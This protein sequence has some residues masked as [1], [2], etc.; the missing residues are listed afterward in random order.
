M[1]AI[2]QPNSKEPLPPRESGNF[3]VVPL[4]W[5]KAQIISAQVKPLKS[6]NGSGLNLELG[7]L[8]TGYVNRKVWSTL[9][10]NHSSPQVERIG[11]QQLQEL[12]EATGFTRAT[13]HDD[14]QL[15]GKIVLVKLKIDE[16]KGDYPAR[17]QASGFA[18]LSANKTLVPPPSGMTTGGGR[19]AASSSTPWA[20]GQQQPAA[21]QPAAQQP[22]AQQ[23]IPQADQ[24]GAPAQT[25]VSTA[26]PR[27]GNTPPWQR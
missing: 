26:A 19:P 10:V 20:N 1:A 4:G 2:P 18:P 7:L 3:P 24:Q 25:Q 16:A 11:Q 6:N 13:F 9:N 8:S 12:I 14:S 15:N 27:A 17:N 21:Q 22:A 5:Y 23:S